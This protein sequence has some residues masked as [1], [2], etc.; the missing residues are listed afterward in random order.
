MKEFHL[1]LKILI[2][3]LQEFSSKTNCSSLASSRKC[4]NFSMRLKRMK[5]LEWKSCA[6]GLF[7]SRQSRTRKISCHK[8][9]PL[10]SCNDCHRVHSMSTCAN[11]FAF[12]RCIRVSMA[13]AR[14]LFFGFPWL[15]NPQQSSTRSF[16]Y[17]LVNW[18]IL[19]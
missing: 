1:T 19:M 14:P 6:D 16:T 10:T 13:T 12:T 17:L 2:S 18:F 8:F 4:I 3:E 11:R 5:T 15:E 7:S 9:R